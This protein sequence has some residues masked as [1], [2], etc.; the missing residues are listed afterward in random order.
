MT[1][2]ARV[3]PPRSPPPPGPPDPL[4]DRAPPPRSTQ[5]K[6]LQELL[7]RLDAEARTTA[8]RAAEAERRDSQAAA[9]LARAQKEMEGAQ[10]KAKEILARA[11][12]E[13]QALLVDIKRKVSEEWERL[14]SEERSKRALEATRRR[15]AA[16]APPAPGQPARTRG[17]TPP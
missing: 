10:A 17:P 3:T 12:A 13:A 1:A 9:L 5:A 7:Q 2:P 16:S 11:K 14:K 4:T 6:N 15:L 8:D